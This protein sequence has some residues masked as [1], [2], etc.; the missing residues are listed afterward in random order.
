MV[1]SFLSIYIA[2]KLSLEPELVKTV[3]ISWNQLKPAEIS[4]ISLDKYSLVWESSFLGHFCGK[5]PEATF[6]QI[7]ANSTHSAMC[8]LVQS[9]AWILQ[10]HSPSPRGTEL[11]FLL[12]M[13]F[14]LG[15]GLDN[16]QLFFPSSCPL[17]IHWLGAFRCLNQ[18]SDKQWESWVITQ[19]VVTY[20]HTHRQTDT[21]FYSGWMLRWLMAMDYD[22][23]GRTQVVFRSNRAGTG[24]GWSL[25][26]TRLSWVP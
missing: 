23:V 5:L 10:C 18:Y 9:L 19:N 4:W 17:C 6:D 25:Y 1:T 8:V 26:L 12:F 3:K 22:Y 21:A 24:D 11:V 14:G 7:S 20:R 13:W 16:I 2:A 15:P